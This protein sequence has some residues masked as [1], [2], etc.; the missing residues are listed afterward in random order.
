MQLIW[1][2]EEFVI[3]GRSYVGFPILLYDT[4]DSAVEV[5]QFLRSYLMR[6][7]IGS[8]QSWQSTARALYDYFGFLQAHGLI[9]TEICRGERKSLI[10]AYRDYCLHDVQLAR[11]TV[12][13]RLHYICMFYEYA[14][15]EQWIE[16]LPFELEDRHIPRSRSDSLTSNTSSENKRQVRDVMPRT[17]KRLPKFLSSTQVSALLQ[18]IVNPHHLMIVRFA[19][20]TGLRREEIATFPNSYVF[21]PDA[22]HGDGRNVMIRLDPQ[23]G[24]GIKTKGNKPRD[25]WIPRDFMAELYR[26]SILIRG[27]IAP[28]GSKSRKTLFLTSMG[29]SYTNHG[30][31]IEV[32]VRKAGLRAG[33]KAHTH[34]LRHTYATHTLSALQRN[35]QKNIVEPLAFLQRQL[36]HASI[37]TTMIYLHLINSL[38]DDAILSYADELSVPADKN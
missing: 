11:N 3:G 36:G 24:S 15:K 37:N 18:A 12:R 20:R 2:T 35:R 30:K 22:G 19:L 28:H 16:R 29:D 33:F 34:I 14:L 9:W 13:Q 27:A 38:V 17:H 10:A 7:V 6:G 5:N 23:D 4:M 25:I 1:S 31:H 21:N 32:M 26:Y 8:S